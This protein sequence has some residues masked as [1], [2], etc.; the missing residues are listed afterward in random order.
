MAYE[1]QLKCEGI[2]FEEGVELLK[3]RVKNPVMLGAISNTN[4]ECVAEIVDVLSSIGISVRHFKVDK[5]EYFEFISKAG[6]KNKYPDYY[7]DNFY[8]KTVEHFLCYSFLDLRHDD[9]FIDIASEHS[10][11]K[12]IFSS[13]TGCVAYSQDIMYKPGIHG[14]KIG[15]NASDLPVLDQSFNAAVATCSIEHFEN[16][17]DVLFMNEM[18]RILVKGGRVVIAPLYIYSKCCCQTDPRY[19]IPGNVSFD[20]DAT[21]YCTKGWGNRH[22]RFY[23]P[24]S[25]FKRLIAPNRNMEFVVYVLENL[26]EIDPSVYCKFVLAGTRI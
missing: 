6:Y 16:K 24:E 11:V 1:Y 10:P 17:S 14:D 19:S 5:K 4:S 25:L 13:L 23:S 8:E 9:K 15:S 2:G 26:E 18:E 3:E 20:D 21:I 7:K 22:G 12:D